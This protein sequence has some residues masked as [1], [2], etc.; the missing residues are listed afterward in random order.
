MPPAG[1]SGGGA[2]GCALK[3]DRRLASTEKGKCT[4]EIAGGM[5]VAC[6]NPALRAF[7]SLL[8]LKFDE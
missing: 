1:G 7:Q 2:A 6:F 8:L 3:G 5:P 4:K